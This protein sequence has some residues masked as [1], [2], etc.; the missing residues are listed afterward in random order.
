M[1]NF[2]TFSLKFFPYFALMFNLILIFFS[3]ENVP[4][5]FATTRKKE[6]VCEIER[7]REHVELLN[8]SN[9]LALSGGSCTKLHKPCIVKYSS[10]KV[11]T[12]I[13]NS[14]C[15]LKLKK[16]NA[17]SKSGR[18]RKNS[19]SEHSQRYASKT[20]KLELF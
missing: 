19:E 7:E 9:T 16:H 2:K 17:H 6:I 15:K 5:S 20:L 13:V 3:F 12:S 18:D 10:E 1:L 14:S 4:I 8:G 11:R